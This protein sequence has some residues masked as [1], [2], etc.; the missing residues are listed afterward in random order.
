MIA[1]AAPAFE[2]LQGVIGGVPGGVPGGVIGGIPGGSL[3]ANAFTPPPPPP[4][5]KVTKPVEA[6]PAPLSVGGDVQAALLIDR[7]TVV[8]PSIAKDARISGT[9]RLHAIIAPDGTVKDLK[10]I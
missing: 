9:V 6:A 3:V 4:A 5:A 2:E 7:K 10:V 8:Y 1:D